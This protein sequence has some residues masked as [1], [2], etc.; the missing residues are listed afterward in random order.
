VVVAEGLSGR[1][2]GYA[3]SVTGPPDLAIACGIADADRAMPTPPELS[4]RMSPP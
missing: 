3:P 1:A 2:A 4:S